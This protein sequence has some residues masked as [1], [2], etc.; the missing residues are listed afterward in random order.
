MKFVADENLHRLV[1]QRLRQEGHEVVAIA[2]TSPGI[3]DDAVLAIAVQENALLLTEN[4]DFGEL[5]FRLQLLAT[6]IVLFRLGTA[7]PQMKA[8]IIAL[9]IQQHG[10]DLSGKFAVIT[11]RTVRIN[12]LSH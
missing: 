4:K 5:V 3:A 2:E 7:S 8:Q 1:I 12:E 10:A 9:A 6:G 11:P